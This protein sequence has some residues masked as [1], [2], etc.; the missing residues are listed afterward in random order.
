MAAPAAANE[1]QAVAAL[2]Q[3]RAR[4]VQAQQDVD[5][6][7]ARNADLRRQLLVLPEVRR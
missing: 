3:A 2:A 7:T 4:R 5:E 1:A 6:K